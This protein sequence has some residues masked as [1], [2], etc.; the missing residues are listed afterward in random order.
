MERIVLVKRLVGILLLGLSVSLPGRADSLNLVEYYPIAQISGV[1]VNYTITG[2]LGH[3]SMLGKA[4]RVLTSAS[5][6]V[7]LNNPT[8]SF[9]TDGSGFQFYTDIGQISFIMDIYFDVP[10]SAT[11]GTPRLSDV[12]NQLRIYDNR[13]LGTEVVTYKSDKLYALSADATNYQFLWRND[14]VTY[15]GGNSFA[16]IGAKVSPG[17]T[18]SGFIPTYATAFNNKFNFGVA[19]IFVTPTPQASVAG[20]FLFSLAPLFGCRRARLK[21]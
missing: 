8:P 6:S 5:T 1:D 14:G 18:L 9:I 16:F 17:S 13:G 4:D 7:V 19:D 15:P 2:N 20:A 10:T 3:L 12:N 21:S 11:V